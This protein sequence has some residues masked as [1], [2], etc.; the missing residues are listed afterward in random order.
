VLQATIAVSLPI[1]ALL[2][3]T[4]AM[5]LKQALVHTDERTKLE[6]ELVAGGAPGRAAGVAAA[7]GRGGGGGISAPELVVGAVVEVDAGGM[8][9]EGLM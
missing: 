3:R 1:N 9:E 4:S 8:L 7:S 2:V 5:M 6:S